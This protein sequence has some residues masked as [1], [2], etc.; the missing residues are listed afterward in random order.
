MCP[1]GV[2]GPLAFTSLVLGESASPGTV[3]VTGN[4]D[5]SQGGGGVLGDAA[6]TVGDGSGSFGKRS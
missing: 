1:G 4:V 2:L 6:V 3:T 5:F